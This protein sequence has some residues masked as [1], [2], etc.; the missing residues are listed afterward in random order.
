MQAVEVSMMPRK[1]CL[2]GVS[3]PVVLTTTI[4]LLMMCP[5]LAAA[6]GEGSLG[7][8]DADFVLSDRKVSVTL[9]LYF[10]YCDGF[11]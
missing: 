7:E 9:S 6:S 3:S 1:S 11:Q 5:P 10:Q 4:L 8:P 2:P